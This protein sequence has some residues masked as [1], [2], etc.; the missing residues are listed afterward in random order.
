M[1]LNEHSFRQGPA[2][3]GKF[4]PGLSVVVGSNNK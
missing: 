2:Q 4:T 3:S 1:I